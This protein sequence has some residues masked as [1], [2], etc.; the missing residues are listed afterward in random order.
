[1]KWA[2]G[3]CCALLVA[4]GCG[5]PNDPFGD[6]F[7]NPVISSQR[8]SGTISGQPWSFRTGDAAQVR[9]IGASQYVVNLYGDTREACTAFGVQVGTTVVTFVLPTAPGD[10]ALSPDLPV[11][12][13]TTMFDAAFT[14]GSLAIDTITA[15]TISGGLKVRTGDRQGVDGRFDAVICP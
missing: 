2:P 9:G 11:E 12:I 4:L 13:K 6:P 3:Y 1:M 10:Y 7:N 8:L 14:E 5:G 15:T